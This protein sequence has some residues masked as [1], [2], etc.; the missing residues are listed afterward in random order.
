MYLNKKKA[1]NHIEYIKD[2]VIPFHSSSDLDT[3]SEVHTSNLKAP[4]MDRVAVT[5]DH[6]LAV[7]VPVRMMITRQAVKNPG[8]NRQ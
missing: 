1:K 8:S 4:A 5:K 6:P 7:L 2:I 3:K